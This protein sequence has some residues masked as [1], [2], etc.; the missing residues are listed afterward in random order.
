MSSPDGI[1][2]P[3]ISPISFADV[4]VNKPPATMY[5]VPQT[6]TLVCL[7]VLAAATPQITPAPDLAKRADST[8]N[9]LVDGICA[10]PY[11]HTEYCS[12]FLFS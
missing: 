5:R 9:P 2:E 11:M 7:A 1:Y 12:P 10:T 8:S 3:R 4:R 6:L